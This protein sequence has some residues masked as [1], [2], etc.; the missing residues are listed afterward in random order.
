VPL[1]R[2]IIEGQ[3]FLLQ[4]DTI[5]QHLDFHR[6]V[7]LDAACIESARH[8]ALDQVITELALHAQIISNAAAEKPRISL[9]HIERIDSLGV[10]CREDEFVWHFP[11]DALFSHKLKARNQ[12]PLRPEE[13]SG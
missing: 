5:L 4:Q 12:L 10:D 3:N 7:C 9:A 1:Y 2:A 13:Q 8:Q 11:G 6:V